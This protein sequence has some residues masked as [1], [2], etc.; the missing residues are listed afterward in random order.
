MSLQNYPFKQ[1]NTTATRNLLGKAGKIFIFLVFLFSLMG[2]STLSARAATITFTGQE[3]LGRPTN[4]SIT[5]SVLP[6]SDIKLY[7]EYGTTSG[8]YPA[9]TAHESATGGQPKVMVISGLSADTKH[10]YRMQYSTF[11]P[12]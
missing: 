9:H 3:L 5:I 10:Y 8:V 1:L 4:T 2:G 12:S 11:R 7:Y 6:D